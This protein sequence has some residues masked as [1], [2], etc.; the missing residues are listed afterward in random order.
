MDHSK[1]SGMLV[2]SSA[3][4]LSLDTFVFACNLGHGIGAEVLVGTSLS[5]LHLRLI[6]ARRVLENSVLNR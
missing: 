3:Y 5:R 4:L 2:Q 6:E 1:A